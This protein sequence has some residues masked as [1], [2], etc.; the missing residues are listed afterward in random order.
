MNIILEEIFANRDAEYRVFS[1]KLLPNVSPDKI[2]GLR[3]P[4]AHSIAKK[5]ANTKE[6]NDFLTSLPHTHYDENM[7]HAF[8]LGRTK[9]SLEEMKLLISRF[10]PYIDNWGVCDGLSSS[11]KSSFKSPELVYDFIIGL[12]KSNHPFTVRFGLVCLLNY[13]ICKEHLEQIL[14]ICQKLS[15]RNGCAKISPASEDYYI[16]MA[17]AWLVSFCLIKEYEST[18]FVIENGLL[19]PWVHNKSIQKAIES[20]QISQEKKNHLRSLKIK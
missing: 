10:L 20:Y 3:S 9:C 12:T 13:Y 4:M 2:L 15:K 7:V 19:S 17:I 8:I 1:Q 6:G 11:L 14:S 16:D 5:Y 18:I